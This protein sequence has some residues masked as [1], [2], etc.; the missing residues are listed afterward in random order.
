MAN[1]YTEFVSDEVI[2]VI[3]KLILKYIEF[4]IML[5]GYFLMIKLYAK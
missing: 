4:L 5:R 2:E 3:L 1:T